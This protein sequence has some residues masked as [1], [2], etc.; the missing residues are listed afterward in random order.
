MMLKK[1]SSCMTLLVVAAMSMS[2][3]L[4]YKKVPYFTDLP[5]SDTI[6]SIN[7]PYESPVIQKNDMISITVGSISPE[8]NAIFGFNAGS[9]GGQS[10]YS[11]GSNYMVDMEGVIEMPLLNKVK[12]EGLTTKQVKELV[13]QKLTSFLK[14]PIVEV[15]ITNFRIV[16]LGAVGTPGMISSSNERL[17]L[18]D[19]ISMAG[20]LQLDAKRN[21][22]L[23]IREENGVRKQIRFNLNSSDVLNS[24]Y[25][26][27]RS[28]DIVYVQP[29]RFGT[30]EINFRNVTYLVAA[31]SIFAFINSFLK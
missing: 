3:C 20:D 8:A 29:G 4:N 30:R 11:T 31:I 17:T 2:S 7:N 18:M 5:A 16:V 27:L 19:A 10:S 25:Y 28:N 15:R 6:A 1:Y 24:P 23:L 14:E 21:N 13:Q 12:V 26:Y 9:A 22:V